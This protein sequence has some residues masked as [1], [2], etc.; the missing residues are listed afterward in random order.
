MRAIDTITPRASAPRA[1]APRPFASRSFASRSLSHRLIARGAAL[2]LALFAL[3]WTSAAAAQTS[4]TIEWYVFEAVVDPDGD[5]IGVGDLW[6][7]EEGDTIWQTGGKIDAADLNQGLELVYLGIEDPPSTA[8]PD[9][10]TTTLS[11]NSSVS[12]AHVF[13]VGGSPDTVFHFE[14]EA[15]CTYDCLLTDVDVYSNSGST[16]DL[17]VEPTVDGYLLEYNTSASVYAG[18]THDHHVVEQTL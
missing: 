11:S 6:V 1:S 15:S 2:C 13:K 17:S 4:G 14:L 9:T 3:A 12:D 18:D 16:L 10:T 7:S 5:A 8:E